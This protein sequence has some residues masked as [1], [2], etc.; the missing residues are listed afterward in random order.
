MKLT[1]FKKSIIDFLDIMKELNQEVFIVYGT[2]LGY[3]RNKSLIKHT[4]DI[5]FA[6]FKIT[7]SIDNI[8]KVFNKYNWRMKHE[9]GKIGY[10]YEISF[11]HPTTKIPIDLFELSYKNKGKLH[12]NDFWYN[13]LYSDL[14]NHMVEKKAICKLFTK[15][16][17][18]LKVPFIGIEVL[19]PENSE[20]ICSKVYGKNYKIPINYTYS[21]GLN[22]SYNQNV[23]E[24]YR[25]INNKQNINILNNLNVSPKIDY[26]LLNNE[27]DNIRIRGRFPDKYTNNTILN[28]QLDNIDIKI[29][30]YIFNYN[31]KVYKCAG[32][33]ENKIYDITLIIKDKNIIIEYN[34]LPLWDDVYL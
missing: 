14:C 20:E 21:Q 10:G 8:K 5:D 1:D 6:T 7:T 12:K 4:S 9:F 30:K 25:W 31:N 19:I 16:I 13:S 34:T 18:L 26:Q 32:G 24:R 33:L 27:N 11:Y 3:V 15:K 23:V 29:V 28:I 22:N 17:N 2:L